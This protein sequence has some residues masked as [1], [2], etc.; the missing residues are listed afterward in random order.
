MDLECSA[1]DVADIRLLL[2]ANGAA[3][4]RSP[5][6]GPQLV[7]DHMNAEAFRAHAKRVG[8]NAVPFLGEFF[9]NGLR[10]IFCDSLEVG[11]NLY[12]SDDFLAEF[13][14]RRGYGLLPYLPILKVRSL[15]E[16]FGEY[17]DSLV[18]DMP[19]I[20]NQ[21]RRDHRQTVSDLM[22]ERFYREFNQWAHDHKLLARTQAHGAP[23]DVLRVYGEADI[24]ETET[25]YDGGAHN[26]LK[27][28]ASSAHVY[29]RSIVGSESFVWEGAYTRPHPKK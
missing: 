13:R 3:R 7:M 8:N 29:G 20:G 1:W 12:W 15:A 4:Q 18:F 16:P 11:A 25:L 2:S 9:G 28:A 5:P 27:M 21:V 22:I 14:R 19:D 23:V 10:A 24:P 6:E 26:F 17:A